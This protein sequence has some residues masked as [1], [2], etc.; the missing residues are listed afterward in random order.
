[1]SAK[2][3][4]PA[5][6]RR[7]RF[8][9]RVYFH[10]LALLILTGLSIFIVGRLVISPSIQRDVRPFTMW[11]VK[12]TVALRSDPA[13][14][15]AELDVLRTDLKITMTLYDPTSALIGTNIDPP[16]PALSPDEVAA[17]EREP[18]GQI[19]GRGR[20]ICGFMEQGQFGGYAI[21]NYPSLGL[22]LYRGAV[23]ITVALLVLALASIPLAR[24]VVSPVETLA[25][26]TRSFGAG[27][28]SARANLDRNDEIGDLA[29]AFDEMA[30][31]VE[32]LLRSERELLANISHELRT[33]LARIRVVLDLASEVDAERARRYVAEI[34]EDLAE[35]ERLVEDVLTAARLELAEGKASGIAPPL[36]LEPTDLQALIDKIA[37]RFRDGHPERALVIDGADDLPL[38]DAD[39]PMLRRVLDN[40]LDNAR[41]YSDA[42]STIRITARAEG[43]HA[44]VEVADEG[45]GIEQAD[46]ESV[47]TPFFRSD[48]SRARQTGGVGLGLTLARRIIEAHAG[49]ITITSEVGAG[50]TVRFTVPVGADAP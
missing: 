6:G 4:A 49:E 47:F 32:L 33:P 39:G 46:L 12:H 37:R 50:T 27:N 5:R 20:A 19:T 30:E 10:G 38:V 43:D 16:F 7:R 2:P 21:T 35:L 29:R 24:S 41:K 15:Q 25:A 26:V 3:L 42:G 13:K 22:S 31:R 44:T 34:A 48:R 11:M 36:R 8:L 45:I 40:L 14:L 17:L 23:L 1:V 18:F 9:L 28:M